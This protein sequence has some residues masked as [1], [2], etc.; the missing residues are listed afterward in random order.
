MALTPRLG[1]SPPTSLQNVGDSNIANTQSGQAM[2]MPF[3]EDS[4]LNKFA[5]DTS[6]Y[7]V[8]TKSILGFMKGKRVSVTYYRLLNGEGHNR[9]NVSDLPTQRNVL[10]TEYQKII[11]LEIT[12]QKG[13]EFT[14]NPT[15]ANVSLKGQAVFYPNMNPSIGDIFMMGTGD[16]RVGLCRVSA[17]Q[18][19]SWRTDTIYMVEFL[20]QEFVDPTVQ[21]PIE[22]SVTLTMVFDKQ[23]YLG[24]TAALLSE[25]TYLQL[26]QIEALRRTLCKTY[27][28]TFFD[29]SLGSYVHPDGYYDPWVV[30]FLCG[31]ITLSDV[32]VRPKNLLG[33]QDR[34][35]QKTLWAR[36]E[37]R[38]N[39]SLYGISAHYGLDFYKQDRMG[40]FVTEL[41]GRSLVMPSDDPDDTPY[42]YSSSFYNST[43]ITMTAEETLVYTAVTQ[44]TMGDLTQFITVYLTPVFSLA[45]KDQFYKIP[46]YIH[47]I[48][49]A[50]QNQYREIDAPSMNYATKPV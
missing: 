40:V 12:L 32:S 45:L 47:L 5:I 19:M 21:D 43:P 2:T 20:V 8:T 11:N 14:A 15:Q 25:Q 41:Y 35:Y 29:P 18:P 16:G 4:N 50:L 17:V 3:I 9:T 42:L 13:F 10:R 39:P 44:K 31:K 22:G 27:H 28:Q 30:T 38:D 37:D 6:Q 26:R 23:N 7:P 36:L 46:L 33:V 34:L 48:D 1:S 24:E 49:M